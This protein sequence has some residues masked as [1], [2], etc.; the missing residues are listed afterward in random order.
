[1][2]AKLQSSVTE[3]LFKGIQIRLSSSINEISNSGLVLN[4][5]VIASRV[6]QLLNSK[7]IIE[8]TISDYLKGNE[9]QDQTIET[10]DTRI[11]IH[12]IRYLE[13]LIQ[14]LLSQNREKFINSLKSAPDLISEELSDLDLLFER[15]AEVLLK[16]ENAFD[17]QSF[18][19]CRFKSLVSLGCLRPSI[20]CDIFMSRLKDTGCST[21]GK[22][23]VYDL[24]R[25]ISRKLSSPQ[26]PA[27]SAPLNNKPSKYQA[28]HERLKSKTKR[29]VSKPRPLNLGT[30][31][32]FYSHFEKYCSGVLASI[33][34]NISYLLVSKGIYTL[35]E[36]IEH[37]GPSCGYNMV[38]QCVYIIKNI[39][40]PFIDYDKREVIESVLILFVT[41]AQKLE[42]SDYLE[43]HASVVQDLA[44]IKLK[45]EKLSG[46]VQELADKCLLL[47]VNYRI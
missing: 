8:Y 33:T 35:S 17:Y 40:K 30:P 23:L 45:I 27:Q 28:I 11:E 20:I 9:Y 5:Q 4:K 14:G 32:L 18:E 38:T 36:I 43:S 1:M 39:I 41:V 37:S 31:N 12:N 24:I 16:I 3:H 19:E 34:W 7:E 6:G 21:S 47:L 10:D 44:D 2:H 29:F 15:L 26:N 42:N 13:D 22:L 25:E 46:D